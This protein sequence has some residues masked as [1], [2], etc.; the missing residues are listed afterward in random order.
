[1]DLRT[2]ILIVVIVVLAVLVAVPALAATAAADA[3]DIFGC[4]QSRQPDRCMRQR[5][6]RRVRCSGR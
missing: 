5:S 3:G 4:L 6:R 1:M 2:V